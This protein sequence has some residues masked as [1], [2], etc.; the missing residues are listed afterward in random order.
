L[1]LAPSG[2]DG[3]IPRKVLLQCIGFLGLVGKILLSFAKV[4][5]LLDININIVKYNIVFDTFASEDSAT[6][7]IIAI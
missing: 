4:C 5:K 6:S 3:G 2:Q 1:T 7:I